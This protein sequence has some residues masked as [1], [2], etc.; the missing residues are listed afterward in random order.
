M[1]HI[2]GVTKNIFS[3]SCDIFHL[4]KIV[5][6]QIPLINV[7]YVFRKIIIIL[8]LY[9]QFIPVYLL[10]DILTRKFSLAISNIILVQSNL[11]AQSHQIGGTI[12][13]ILQFAKQM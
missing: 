1:T 4:S 10:N 2:Y 9:V 13:P 12:M 11:L 7:V 8:T 6:T 3:V 5:N